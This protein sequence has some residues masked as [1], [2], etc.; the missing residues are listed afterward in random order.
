MPHDDDRVLLLLMGARFVLKNPERWNVR[1]RARTSAGVECDVIDPKAFTFSV[2]GALDRILWEYGWPSSLVEGAPAR[3]YVNEAKALLLP[4][5]PW[6]QLDAQLE[7]VAAAMH[8]AQ[9]LR[10]FDSVIAYRES[11]QRPAMAAGSR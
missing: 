11:G 4:G 9:L 2:G 6:K 10:W 1:V 8:H 5:I 7:R 3:A